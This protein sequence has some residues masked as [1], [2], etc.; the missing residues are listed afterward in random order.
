MCIRIHHVVV[1][2]F[3]RQMHQSESHWKFIAAGIHNVKSHMAMGQN[4]QTWVSR[5]VKTQ[6]FQILN[7]S[8]IH[9]CHGQNM[10]KYTY[11]VYGHSSKNGIL[12]IG[13]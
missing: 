11:V 3:F 10:S 4:D 6:T 2:H 13:I 12:I 8:R 7:Q 9:M 1:P 5:M